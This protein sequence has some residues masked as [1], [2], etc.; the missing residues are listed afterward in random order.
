MRVQR[1][2]QVERAGVSW[3]EHL[4][5]ADMCWLFRP[6]DIA[7]FGIDAHLEI[8]DGDPAEPT[9]RLL[10]V[11][12]KSG[13]S[14]FKAATGSGWWFHCSA[15]HVAYWL[16]HSLP[17][18]VMLYD[19][20]TKQVYW[21]H[22]NDRTI[23]STG[24]GSK[25]HV[26]KNQRLAANSTLDLS[27]LAR[28]QADVPA[29]S[30]W[31]ADNADDLTRKA[32]HELVLSA[33]LVAMFP[34]CGILRREWD[35]FPRMTVQLANPDVPQLR[36]LMFDVEVVTSIFTAARLIAKFGRRD[37]FAPLMIVVVDERPDDMSPNLGA[38]PVF[39]TP[40]SADGRYDESLRSTL[41]SVLLWCSQPDS[42]E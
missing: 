24:K 40:W 33:R 13:S 1:T 41:N 34:D 3:I 22:V 28:S 32:F 4:V 37:R 18:V 38:P 23:V 26:P 12:I 15:E 11:Q 14:Y 25:I 29:V 27:P 35:E 42:K 6:Q 19:P 21:Q 17:V 36:G 2:H 9:G 8:V 31:L 10:G 7:D 39:V 5:T 20:A 16:G 30:Q